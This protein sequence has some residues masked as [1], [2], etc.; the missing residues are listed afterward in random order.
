M[1][2][3]QSTHPDNKLIDKAGELP[4]PGQGSRSGGQIAQKVGTRAELQAALGGEPSV[5]RVTG[6][7]DPD[8]DAVKGPKTQE[9]YDKGK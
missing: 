8:A 5:E 7:D 6:H 2:K 1:P 3:R 4:T 9:Q